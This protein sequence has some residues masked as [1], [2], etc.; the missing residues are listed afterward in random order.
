M[1]EHVLDG[2]LRECGVAENAE[3]GGV[4]CVVMLGVG[5]AEPC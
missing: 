4:H 1:H 2:V 5:G 3:R